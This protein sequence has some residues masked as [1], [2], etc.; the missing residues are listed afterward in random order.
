MHMISVCAYSGET[1]CS[2]M[3]RAGHAGC[4]L[5]CCGFVKKSADLRRRC[6]YRVS[7]GLKIK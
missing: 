3:P 5:C 7:K 2:L 6:R 4:L 1:D